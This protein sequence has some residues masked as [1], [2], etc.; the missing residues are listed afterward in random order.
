MRAVIKL[1]LVGMATFVVAFAM[2]RAFFWDVMPVSWNEESSTSGALIAAYLL[3]SLE[4]LGV[5]VAAIAVV[6]GLV[7][8][9]RS[10]VTKQSRFS[11]LDRSSRG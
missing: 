7:V 9:A 11:E 3:L 6:T 5:G 8:L 4:N 2:R 10:L 1:A